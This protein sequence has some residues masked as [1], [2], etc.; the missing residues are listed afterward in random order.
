L[1]KAGYDSIATAGIEGP[2]EYVLDNSKLIRL[3]GKLIELEEPVF[4]A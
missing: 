2:E 3:N 4:D 1:Q